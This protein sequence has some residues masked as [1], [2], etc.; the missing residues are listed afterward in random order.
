MLRKL[1][2]AFL[3]M[4]W[5]SIAATIITI[6]VAVTL[7][8]I[9]LPDIGDYREDVQ[10]FV[11][12]YT[13]YPVQIK[14]IDARWDGWIPNLYLQDITVLDKKGSKDLVHFDRAYME[15][16]PV[17]SI[18]QRS[19]VPLQL[20]ISGIDLSISRLED[21]SIIIVESGTN[22]FADDDSFE[23]KGLTDWLRRQ[24]RIFI[25]NANLSWIDQQQRYQ[26]LR[27]KNATLELLS[28][29]EEFTA[30]GT[31]RLEQKI[32]DA[33]V[34]YNINIF[35]DI[36]SS[37]WSGT[38]N[39]NSNGLNPGEW[40]NENALTKLNFGN[41]QGN[42]NIKSKFKFAKLKQLVA[43][44]Q[45]DNFSLTTNETP[46]HLSN[47]DAEFDLL[48]KE[49]KKWILDIQLK[50]L[51]TKNGI[52]KT[53]GARLEI[54]R[55]KDILDSSLHAIIH[56]I[57][58]DD[59]KDIRNLFLKTEGNNISAFISEGEIRNFDLQFVPDSHGD[60]QVL[61]NANLENFTLS[62][63]NDLSL[64]GLSGTLSHDTESGKLEI[65]SKNVK[66]NAKNLYDKTIALDQINGRINWA[67]SEGKTIL[68][69]EGIHILSGNIPIDIK[70]DVTIDQ[71]D[72]DTFLNLDISSN[73]IPLKIVPSYF[74]ITTPESVFNWLKNAL[75][76]GQVVSVN[77]RIEGPLSK[78]PYKNGDGIFKTEASV[79]DAS[80]A[81]HPGWPVIEKINADLDIDAT[82]LTI[83]ASHGK[84]F[85]ADMKDVEAVIA[86]LV[87]KKPALDVHGK[88]EGNSQD[89]IDYIDQSP[90][91]NHASLQVPGKNNL[92]GPINLNITL[93]IPLQKHPLIEVKGNVDLLDNTI[94]SENTGIQLQEL[95]GNIEFTQNTVESHDLVA[96][97]FNHPIS[98]KIGNTAEN[99]QQIILH[100]NMDK[101]FIKEQFNHYFPSNA[102]LVDDYLDQINGRSS[103]QAKIEFSPENE[104]EQKLI[105][106][107]DLKGMGVELPV[108]L[109][110]KP[111]DRFPIKLE[112][113]L[114]NNSEQTLD[115]QFSNLLATRLAFSK[116][117]ETELQSLSSL[118]IAFG[119]KLED[120]NQKEG[121]LLN[122]K[123]D[124]LNLSEW[125][126]LIQK[127][128]HQGIEKE[129]SIYDDIQVNIEI[130]QLELFNQQFK[131]VMLEI[132]KPENDWHIEIDSED[133]AGI[134]SI[135]I[136]SKTIVLNL[137]RLKLDTTAEEDKTEESIEIDPVDLPS[138][139]AYVTNFQYADIQ[140]GEMY[141]ET[142]KIEHGLSFDNISFQK[143]NIE[144]SAHGEW[145]KRDNKSESL[146]NI[147]LDATELNSMLETFNYG[148][149][150]IKEG[151]TD[152]NIEAKWPGSP[153]DFQL[154]N[155]DGAMSLIINKGQ[156][157][158]INPKAGRL[159]GLLSL[160]SLPRRLS[161]DFSDL[162]G[163]GL[164]FD[165]I[166][167]AFTLEK[168][169]AYTNDLLMKG[170]SANIAITGRTGLIDKDYDQL[171]TV[172]PQITDSLP[173]ASALFGPIGVGVGTVI[174]FASELFKSIPSNIDKML[175]YQ[176]TITGSWK[177][178]VVE[179][180]KQAEKASG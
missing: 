66:L 36:L 60:R 110:K 35:G 86:D 38:I 1:I 108:P 138:I 15:L 99:N 18:K 40:L 101:S 159:F 77:S 131:D 11:S 56:H 150:S 70:G 45:F 153:M 79:V 71:T 100:G 78:F 141:L 42:I 25:E 5:Y 95:K 149:T 134:I 120:L 55:S 104:S 89:L 129:T 172:T 43:K 29:L 96:K 166:E 179:K 132:N 39:L 171:V 59:L 50:D 155:L 49:G 98:L 37:D 9:F 148:L 2:K 167:G 109:T 27:L 140:L 32:G 142:S 80:V 64:S 51:I 133:I 169:N 4:C 163:K 90:L 112:T 74:P 94:D 69:T 16:D 118:N 82:R 91:K 102:D 143:E 119:G 107:S 113:F 20:K 44:V 154:Q 76:E 61:I 116:L 156:V 180:Y 127:K 67:S 170:P 46:F 34:N 117:T 175:Q 75:T 174:Y 136:E 48:R 93:M 6:A 126:K 176:Y 121:I 33:N 161:L 115:M 145:T 57:K 97:Y 135:P 123:I 111:H 137:S 160:Q 30:N 106:T 7:L 17:A 54:N 125:L 81:Y 24:K 47:V 165:Q 85:D 152:I 14:K 8:R 158:D 23:N 62:D 10:L 87:G 63:K 53:P 65:T 73:N 88:V 114:S 124:K 26:P 13:G 68:D 52:W 41:H 157:L 130:S 178:P 12:E 144:I 164:S 103:W 139:H 58:I 92:N 84:I 28:N 168:G 22:L 3:H 151:K 19:I 83:R 105:I 147:D 173:V 177:D 122:G 162:F 21:G 72:S 146:F 128:S 31:A